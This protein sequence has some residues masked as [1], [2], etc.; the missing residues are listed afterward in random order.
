VLALAAALSRLWRRR[1]RGDDEAPTGED[2]AVA[3][4]AAGFLG[5]G[6]DLVEPAV[7]FRCGREGDR[8]FGKDGFD[9]VKC[10]ECA[11]AF[12][13]PRLTPEGRLKL[14]GDSDYFDGGVYASFWARKLQQIWIG[15]RLDLI[16][17][18]L[19]TAGGRS[20]F[21]VGCA[22]GVFL[23]EAR[24][25]GFTVGG[26]EYSPFAAEKAS[27]ILG[28]TIHVGEVEHLD[29]GDTHYDAIAFWDV[30]E[31]VPDPAAFMRK[32]V[33]LTRPGGVVALSCPYFDSLPARLLRSRWWTFKPHK[34]PSH[35][36]TDTL[37]RLMRESGLDPLR[38]VRA[39][40]RRA[41]FT[42][43]DSLVLVAR[44]P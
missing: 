26:L 11:Q 41:N 27:E 23:D 40:L 6:P 43:L 24:E 20:I 15:G 17:E 4:D 14:Y 19:Q 8:R 44:R 13:T 2:A 22:Y 7:C 21:E 34:H 16:E 30:L 10:P 42:R 28:V 9:L 36:T 29:I 18:A 31:H 37:L 39:P 38:V 35:F 5:F 12:V 25:R 3:E 1:P 32:V 33:S